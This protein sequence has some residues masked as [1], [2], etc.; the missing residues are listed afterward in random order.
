MSCFSTGWQRLVQTNY[1]PVILTFTFQV[2]TELCVSV[3]WSHATL[4]SRLVVSRVLP[5]DLFDLIIQT[6]TNSMCNDTGKQSL[7]LHIYALAVYTQYTPSYMSPWVFTLTPFSFCQICFKHLQ[8][9]F[10][11]HL[12]DYKRLIHVRLQHILY[13]FLHAVS[14]LLSPCSY[15]CYSLKQTSTARYLYFN[16]TAHAAHV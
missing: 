4:Q 2:S 12:H 8:I 6:S 13:N 7:C 11:P 3:F 9:H 15:G 1:Q 16:M 5:C 14:W 10:L